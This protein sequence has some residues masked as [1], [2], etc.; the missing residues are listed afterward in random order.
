M[1]VVKELVAFD[2]TWTDDQSFAL[3]EELSNTSRL[4]ELGI[5]EIHRLSGA[6]D[7]HHGALQLLAQ[8]FE[9]L[10]KCTII[11][12][13]AARGEPLPTQNDLRKAWGH[14][15]TEAH[16]TMLGLISEVPEFSRRPVASDDI[17]FLKNDADLAELLEILSIFG[18]AGRY[19]DLDAI[20]S[21]DDRDYD[22]APSRIWSRLEFQLWKADGFPWANQTDPIPAF[23][24]INAAIARVFDRYARAIARAWFLGAVGPAGRG[25]AVGSLDRWNSMTDD[26]LGAPRSL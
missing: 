1:P 21:N 9:R 8:G 18:G 19:F 3:L 20:V 15:L 4:I 12:S 17:E 7:F 25:N 2:A 11:V 23:E 13:I 10:V 24:L 16:A 22:L 26:Q 5:S 14:R 6:N